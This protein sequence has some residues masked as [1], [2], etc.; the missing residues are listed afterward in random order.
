MIKRSQTFDIEE[1]EFEESP[2]SKK[3]ENNHVSYGP[4][5]TEKNMSKKVDY[6]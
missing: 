2:I 3:R 4:V 5:R 6:S 1:F